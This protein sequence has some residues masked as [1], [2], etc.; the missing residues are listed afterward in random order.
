MISI[1]FFLTGFELIATFNALKVT[2]FICNY[3]LPILTSKTASKTV[4]TFLRTLRRGTN[5]VVIE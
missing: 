1:L 2:N 3:D 5:N 4:P